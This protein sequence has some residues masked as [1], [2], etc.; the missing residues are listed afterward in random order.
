MQTE[1]AFPVTKYKKD[2]ELIPTRDENHEKPK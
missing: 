2:R 1:Y